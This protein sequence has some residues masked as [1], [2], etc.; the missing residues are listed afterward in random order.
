AARQAGE[1]GGV[2][3]P[4]PERKDLVM[5]TV[6]APAPPV[7]TVADLLRNLGDIPPERIH[8]NPYPATEK[9]VIEAEARFNRLCELVDGVL[10]EKPMGWYESRLAATLIG[11]MEMFFQDHDV[12]IVLSA[13]GMVR[14]EGQVRMPDVSFLAW[15][16]FPNR[17]LPQGSI[18][19]L[20][21]DLAVEVLS[22]SNTE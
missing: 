6:S 18:L 9:D 7:E 3:G 4:R 19:D 2:S 20:T 14:T 15:S 17:L 11:F 13:D 1:Q 22:P 5:A 21:P 10:V 12:G 16:H 8:L